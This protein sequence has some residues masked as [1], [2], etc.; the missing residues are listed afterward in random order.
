MSFHFARGG[1]HVSRGATIGAHVGMC[2]VTRLPS[3]AHPAAIPRRCKNGRRAALGIPGR[4][5][6]LTRD[7][8]KLP[9]RVGMPGRLLLDSRVMDL[10]MLSNP[11]VATLSSLKP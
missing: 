9:P 1:P 11:V 2:H 8:R 6:G 7:E 4:V 5:Q 3:L 10:P